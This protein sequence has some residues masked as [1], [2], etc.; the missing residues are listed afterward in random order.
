LIAVVTGVAVENLSFFSHTSRAITLKV[1][2]MEMQGIR[3]SRVLNL[4]KRYIVCFSN[5]LEAWRAMRFLALVLLLIP[6]WSAAQTIQLETTVSPLRGED[7]AADCHYALTI[8]VPN[9]PIRAV[10]VI[11]DRGHDVHDLYGDAAV[12]AFARRFQLAL[13]LHGHC[14]GKDSEDHMDMNMD[15]SKGLGRALFSA[16]DQFAYTTGHRELSSAKLIY[17]GFS[18][19]GPLCARLVGSNPD[20]ALAA[21]LSSP[22][23][24][25]PL[26]IDTVNL[27]TQALTVPELIIAGSADDISGTARPYLYFRRYRD[28]GA[29]WAFILQNKSPHCC[30]ANAK[31]LMLL[32]LEAVIEQRRPSFSKKEL[33]EMDQRN[34]WLA[35]FKTQETGTSD[36]FGLKTFEVVSARIQKSRYRV[37]QESASSAGWLPNHAIALEWLSFVQQQ[38]HP[39]LPLH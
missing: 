35:Y 12:L 25:D 26:G 13:L 21:I 37:P 34:G 16:L 39:I 3:N 22:G 33:H 5:V 2:S 24:Y 29:P 15:P 32:W 1:G 7:I 28:L 18:G 10:W 38:Q 14:P 20:R 11:F 31:D 30:T 23:H 36:S 19:A 9:H 4:S 17:L 8:T 27:N 6:S